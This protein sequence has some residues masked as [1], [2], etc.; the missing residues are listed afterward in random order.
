MLYIENI[1]GKNGNSFPS[2]YK[3]KLASDFITRI[4]HQDFFLNYALVLYLTKPKYL[5]KRKKLLGI[6]F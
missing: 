4:N 2:S 6:N 3:E 1:G 5:L